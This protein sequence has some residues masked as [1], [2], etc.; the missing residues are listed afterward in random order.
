[1]TQHKPN[2]FSCNRP[3]DSGTSALTR[4]STPGPLGTATCNQTPECPFDQMR[5]DFTQHF[6]VPR[7]PPSA[8]KTQFAYWTLTPAGK[9]R[10]MSLP[11]G[12]PVFVTLGNHGYVERGHDLIFQNQKTNC[13]GY[14]LGSP[15]PGTI[16]PKVGNDEFLFSPEYIAKLLEPIGGRLLLPSMLPLSRPAPCGYFAID[17]WRGAGIGMN[18]HAF[19]ATVRAWDPATGLI[20][21]SKDG[22]SEPIE[23]FPFSALRS[24]FG[25]NAGIRYAGTPVYTMLIP[26]SCIGNW[27]MLEPS[28]MVY[29]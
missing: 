9:Q 16:W 29:Q 11:K 18:R 22:L 24:D 15:R 14:A 2:G 26:N 21:V 25:T 3:N 13:L 20:V 12:V 7:I 8:A 19:H 5:C 6:C 4:A 28:F 17:I 10:H 23:N 27:E 1:M